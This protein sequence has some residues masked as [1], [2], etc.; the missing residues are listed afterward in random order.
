MDPAELSNIVNTYVI[1][2]GIKIA[3]ALVIF[4][5]GRLVVS[6]VVNAVSKILRSR[7][8]DEILVSF[9]TSI[10]RWVL[11]LFL[12]LLPLPLLRAAGT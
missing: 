8:M 6:I 1:P 7:E 11:L 3:L 12:L 9:L 2:W 4:Y 5:V 10:L